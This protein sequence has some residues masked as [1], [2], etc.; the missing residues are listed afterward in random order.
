[1]HLVHL[2]IAPDA[3]VSSLLDWTDSEEYVSGNT[4]EKRLAELWDHYRCFCEEAH[5]GDRASRKLFS[6]A[7]L[8][9]DSIGYVEV[10]QKKLSATAARYM[11]Y[12]LS[13]VAKDYAL[14][15]AKD[16]D[17]QL[18]PYIDFVFSRHLCVGF[19]FLV[20]HSRRLPHTQLILTH[21]LLSHNSSTH[22]L[23]THNLSTQN[24]LTHNL[25][26]HNLLTHNLSTQNLL[27]HNLLTH[28]LLTHNLSTHNLLTH[29][30]STHNLLTHNLLTHNLLTHN[31][32]CFLYIYMYIT[33]DDVF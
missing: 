32:T 29:N 10:S 23:L 6:V 13:N 16:A 25:L 21:N 15:H 7:T 9:P 26:T 8:S 28:N 20:L 11:L 33:K 4:R 31:L 14:T 22:N 1:M 19:L 3:I 30:L 24:L 18:D 2:T 5:I 12:W 17:M 27:T